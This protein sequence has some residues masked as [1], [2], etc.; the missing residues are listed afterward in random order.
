MGSL[1]GYGVYLL[2]S[3][4]QWSRLTHLLSEYI[5]ALAYS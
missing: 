5:M 4:F 3:T 2:G 1:L